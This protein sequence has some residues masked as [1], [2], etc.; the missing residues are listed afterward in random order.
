MPGPIGVVVLGMGRSGTSAAAGMFVR[1]GY[2]AGSP[3]DV[4]P[5]TPDNPL[6]H[7]EN[8]GVLLA[9]EQVL[10][11][12]GGTWSDPP[13]EE[14]QLNARERMLPLL[15]DEVQRVVRDAAGRPVL[16][17]DPRIGVMMPLWDSIVTEWLHPVLVVRDP[18]E[19]AYSLL[20]RD[21]TS[22][23]S[24]IAAWELHMTALLG[25]LN[26]RLATVAPYGP[27][28]ADPRLGPV[29]V[30]TATT[31]VDPARASGVRPAQAR[32]ALEPALHRNRAAETD[33]DRRLTM[34]QR[35]L[36]RLLR[37]LPY[38]DQLI[39]VPAHLRLARR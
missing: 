2:F 7:H 3:D 28:I 13:S 8:L 31:H 14:V 10:T 24:G 6:G 16:I 19:I 9:N 15:R 29:I 26:G 27:M 25:H 21:G 30:E 20:R 22:I 33:H 11:G 36:W 38:G 17:K 35:D 1:A 5:A 34:R 18:V 4:L 23:A 39:E 37:R 32:A 12:L